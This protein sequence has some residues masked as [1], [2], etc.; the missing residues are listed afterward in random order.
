MSRKVLATVVFLLLMGHGSWAGSRTITVENDGSGDF[1]TIQPALDAAAAGDTILIGPGVYS[2]TNE[3]YLPGN[4]NWQD[5]IGYVPVPDVTVI[6]AGK[7]L[8]RLVY[9][10][11]V[12]P[13]KRAFVYLDLGGTFRVEGMSIEGF[14][15][16]IFIGGSILSVNK[17]NFERN[18]TGIFWYSAGSGGGVFNS[19]FSSDDP[20]NSYGL[21]L[22]GLGR[23]MEISDCIFDTNQLEVQGVTNALFSR[24]EIL[25]SRTGIQIE[26]SGEVILQ[27][28]SIHDIEGVG[29]SLISNSSCNIFESEISGGWDAAW[30]RSYGRLFS[31]NSVFSGGTESVILLDYAQPISMRHCD[32]IKGSSEL[33]INCNTQPDYYPVRHDFRGNFWGTEDGDQIAEWIYDGHDDPT[34]HAEVLYTPFATGDSDLVI[35]LTPVDPEII[36]PETG[37]SFLY[38]ASIENNTGIDIVADLTIEAVLPD[39]TAYPVMDLPGVV[40]AGASVRTRIDIVQEVPAAAPA[41]TYTYRVSASLGD[42]LLVDTAELPFEKLGGGVAAVGPMS[43]SV[44]GWLDD[45]RPPFQAGAVKPVLYGPVPNPFNP[46]TTVAFE[47]PTQE[48][49][50]LHV[51]DLQGRLVRTLL[52]GEVV[53]QGRHEAVWDGRD[54]SGR[55]AAS[56]TYF[57]RLQAGGQVETKRA[58]LVK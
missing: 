27:D 9:A 17:C 12:H 22:T 14:S 33:T 41:G 56:G 43:W 36:I 29:I 5:I 24:C 18:F 54:E 8:T 2:E 25:G 55:Q 42:T 49:V 4:G 50:S 45:D 28:C 47:L 19:R 11:G 20:I 1:S 51:F 31:L 23:D 52:R 30:V 37:G 13:I 48:A 16:G 44:T 39:G 34:V 7:E 38:D 6:G 10:G 32:L 58:V 35:G 21:W 15:N 57:F 3:Y 40:L 46:T 26:N 53:P